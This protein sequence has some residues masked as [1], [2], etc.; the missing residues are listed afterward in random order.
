MKG[1]RIAF[2]M[3]EKISMPISAFWNKKILVLPEFLFGRG[4]AKIN[5]SFHSIKRLSMQY[6][7]IEGCCQ[8]KCHICQSRWVGELWMAP[9]KELI[10]YNASFINDNRSGK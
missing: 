5:F 6:T 8:K 1:K 2:I 4:I 10:E 7:E 3:E 9:V